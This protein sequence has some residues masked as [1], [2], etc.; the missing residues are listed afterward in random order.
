MVL[1]PEPPA[2]IVFVTDPERT[3]LP[4]DHE[5][6]ALFGLTMA[7]ARLARTLADGLSLET[8]ASRL[9]VRVGTVRT[10]LKSIFEKTGCHRQADLVRLILVSTAS[11]PLAM[12]SGSTGAI[13]TAQ[14]NR[15]TTPKQD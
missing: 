6:R 9:G 2:A 11:H 4:S 7:E 12:T 3:P 13:S 15:K 1:G 8:A 10:R 14:T 5:I